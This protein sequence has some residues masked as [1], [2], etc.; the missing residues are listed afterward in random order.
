ME[1]V[2]NLFRFF[3]FYKSM[4]KGNNRGVG[5]FGCSTHLKHSI[6]VF[7]WSDNRGRRQGNFEIL[8]TEET[9]AKFPTGREIP[10]SIREKIPAQGQVSRRNEMVVSWTYFSGLSIVK[11]CETK[12]FG[13]D[14]IK[15]D[16]PIHYFQ[17]FRYKK[18]LLFSCQMPNASERKYSAKISN[19]FRTLRSFASHLNR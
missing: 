12:N 6:Q 18:Y 3:A 8:R 1:K 4:S 17:M 13:A 11:T 14:L 9:T 5:H 7:K 19:R 15:S 16:S 10:I 2:N